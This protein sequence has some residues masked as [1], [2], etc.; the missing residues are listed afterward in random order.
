MK[1]DDDLDR[2]LVN[3]EG[4]ATSTP[5]PSSDTASQHGTDKNYQCIGI[6]LD[7]ADDVPEDQPAGAM[8]LVTDHPHPHLT[9]PAKRCQCQ[10]RD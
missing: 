6:N 4:F 9:H 8:A 3:L 1:G 7:I 5:P 2:F 10:G